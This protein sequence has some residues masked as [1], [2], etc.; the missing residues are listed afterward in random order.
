M[1]YT[2]E[3]FNGIRDRLTQQQ[4]ADFWKSAAGDP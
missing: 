4:Q 1:T 2:V 3:G